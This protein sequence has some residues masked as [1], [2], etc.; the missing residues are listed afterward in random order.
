MQIAELRALVP[1]TILVDDD[2]LAAVL[3]AEYPGRAEEFREEAGAVF[4]GLRGAKTAGLR[5]RLALLGQYARLNFKEFIRHHP[6]YCDR[7]EGYAPMEILV[8]AWRQV[9][10]RSG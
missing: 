2:T 7:A 8:T 6:D 9:E 4:E 5:R 3:V 1:T 10:D